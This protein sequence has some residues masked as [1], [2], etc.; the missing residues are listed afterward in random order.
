MANRFKYLAIILSVL[1]CGSLYSQISQGGR[2]LSFERYSLHA[3]PTL[4]LPAPSL[5]SLERE[6]GQSGKQGLPQRVA[7]ALPVNAGI[8]ESGTW[9]SLPDGTAVWRLRLE[10][11]GALALSLC[12]ENF[13]LTE[14]AKLFL[15]D[16]E[17]IFL[18]GAYTSHNNKPHGH[19]ST[20]LI[21]GE[22][23]TLELEVPGGKAGDVTMTLREISYLYRF[24]PDFLEGR[25]TSDYCEVNIHCPEGENWQK[26]KR[27]VV[28]I[29]VKKGG[30]F[31]WCTGS[32]M[33]NA[34]M[35]RTPF[36]LTADHCASNVSTDDLSQWIFYFNFEA[37]G[38]ENPAANPPTT[39]M[40]GASLLSNADVSGSDFMLVLLDE[41]VPDSYSPFFMG[42]TNQDVAGQEGVTIHHPAGDI[43]KISTYLEP[44]ISSQWGSALN[45]HWQ[46][47]WSE[48]GSGWGVTEGGSSGAPL[49]NENGMVI[50]TLTGGLA[51]CD[52]GG[53]GPGTGP[54]KPDYYG[55]FS[56]SWDQN[57]TTP[58]V[59][60]KDWLDPDNSGISF[61]PGMNS[62]LTA[63]FITDTRLVLAGSKV[64]FSDL[65]SGPPTQWSWYFESGNPE[66]H[67]GKTP[68][69]ITYAQ[70]GS[71]LV[72]L[73]VN[74]GVQSDTLVR[75]HYI[76]VVGKVFPN[77]T[78]GKVYI[79]LGE[80]APANYKL[81]VISGLGRVVYKEEHT[82]NSSS[83]AMADLTGQSSGI[84]LVRLELGQRYLFARVLL[85]N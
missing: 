56:Y 24:L 17:K 50:G 85:I 44:V 4:L 46:V 23:V 28:R 55:K 11:P 18:L 14:D 40:T 10:S 5:S 12:F 16:D 22:A 26:Q 3:P 48:T 39:S 43:K 33:N 53:G 73:V 51:A 77:P 59:R 34:R 19:F 49:L 82:D 83:V 8:Q 45:T 78:S 74:D 81:E 35:D 60:L 52:P 2:P 37:P 63:D 67:S 15:Y 42:W 38:C 61:L 13:H 30:A 29:Y 36:L 58:D 71:Y 57:G 41:E 47:Y 79:Y 20:E 69:E 9:T 76:E 75:S 1:S 25:G 27:G 7:V 54:D 6:D 84:Y 31:F 21:P 62:I 66:T 64:T 65:S 80:E 72:R 70:G 68:P 32:L